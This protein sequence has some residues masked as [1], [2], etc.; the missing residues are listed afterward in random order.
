VQVRRFRARPELLR[1]CDQ[2]GQWKISGRRAVPMFT[3]YAGTS[4]ATPWPRVECGF[5]LFL[6][7]LPTGEYRMDLDAGGCLGSTT[8][9]LP[10]K[11]RASRENPLDP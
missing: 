11:T 1:V 6:A 5:F 2:T 9:A 3:G 7:E 10:S 4:P 8:E